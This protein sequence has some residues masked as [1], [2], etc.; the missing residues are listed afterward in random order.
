MVN[1]RAIRIPP[2]GSCR[3]ERRPLRRGL[4][5]G[6]SPLDA[7]AAPTLRSWTSRRARSTRGRSPTRRPARSSRRSTRPPRT[8]RRRSA[9]TRATTTRAPA[10]RRAR[11]SRTCLA[12]LE[13]AATASP[14]R[15]GSA[16]TTTL[17]HLSRPGEHVVS[18]NDVYGGVY[19][20]FTQV[21]EPK[22]YRFTYLSADEVERGPRRAP[23]RAHAD[24]L[25]RDAD[26]PAAEHRRHP[27]GGRGGARRRRD[28]RRRQHV[29]DA[30]T[31]SS[32]SSSA[33][34]SSSTRRPSTSAAT[35]T[36]SAAS[37]ARTTRRSPSACA[38]CRSRWA[39]SRGRST[40]ARPARAEDARRAHAP[41]LRERAPD[42]GLPRAE[43]EAVERVLYPGL[44]DHPGHE[45]ARRQMSDFGGMISFLVD[46]RGGR[47]RARRR[48]EDLEARREPRRRREP[49]RAAGAMTHASTAD[50][51]FALPRN[52]VRL[53]VGIESADDLIADLEQALAQ[54]GAQS[55]LAP[56]GTRPR[57]RPPCAPSRSAPRRSAG[58]PAGRWR[59]PS[60]T[61]GISV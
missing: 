20:M 15:P 43:H 38:S 13:S 59:R 23:R 41:A 6:V 48:D 28:A 35:R 51:P 8:S 46:Y 26:E 1:A 39:R 5:P 17:M 37:S 49:D 29:R 47:G 22:G 45:I 3:F 61:A 52:L 31:S 57:S 7:D 34:T 56:S 14:S 42:R 40:L 44:P 50:A 21:Y 53:S 4:T 33:P 16:A 60:R 10:T 11:P 58:T 9:S 27:R 54:V 36:S 18:V 24:R 55:L 30:R 25:D 12:S 2:R 19:R 32:R